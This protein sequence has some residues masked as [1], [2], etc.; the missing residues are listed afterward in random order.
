MLKAHAE[1]ALITAE[2][3]LAQAIDIY[4]ENKN[5]VPRNLG[6]KF[7]KLLRVCLEFLKEF[8]EFLNGGEEIHE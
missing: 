4:Q 5:Y 2:K 1:K 6:K 3:K 7:Q 8:R